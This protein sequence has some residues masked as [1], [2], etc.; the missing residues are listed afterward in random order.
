MAHPSNKPGVGSRVTINPQSDRTRRILVQG[1]I[2]EFLTKADYHPHG[3]LVRLETG[4]TGRIKSTD[5][6]STNSAPKDVSASISKSLNSL[7]QQG[8]NPYIEFKLSALWSS[9]FTKEDIEA[10]RPQSTELRSYGKNFSKIIVS[11]TIA[12]FLNTDGGTL[13][14]G[15]KENKDTNDD[16]IIGIEPEFSHLKDPCEDGYRRM[17]IDIIKDYFSSDI[18]NHLN[19][20]IN[21]SFENIND[22]LVCG[23]V[24]SKADR[25]VF[26]KLKN[27]EH[28][29]IRIDASTR[30]LHGEEIVDYCIKRFRN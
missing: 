20:Y 1:V 7:I 4:E 14:I 25:K 9:K 18:F 11:K 12:G 3:L 15:I 24:V 19:Q 26:I 17:L 23:V 6:S 13:I 22:A 5:H 27:T 8:E 28:F 29:Y 30:E 16:E 10:Y 2:S 21:I